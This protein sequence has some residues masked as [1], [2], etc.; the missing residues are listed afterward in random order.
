MKLHFIVTAGPTREHLDPV[1]FLSNPSTGKMGFEVAR[2]AAR[3]GHDVVLVAGPCDLPTPKGVQRVD[4]VSAREMKAAVDGALASFP[5]DGEFR[6]VL[7][8]T[9]AVADW[10]PETTAA[11][12]LKKGEMDGV[13]RLVRNPDILAETSGCL[14]IGF[15]AETGDAIE[16]AKRKCREKHA[17]LIVL[18][19]V[20]APGAGFG[21]TTNIVT[22]V[23]CDGK[24]KRLPL[25]PKSS[26]ATKIVHFAEKAA[27]KPNVM[28]LNGWAASE[29]AWDKC[30]FRRDR[31]YSYRDHLSGATQQAFDSMRGGVA[32]V[33][34]SMGVSVALQLALRNP[35]KI[36]ALVL[37]AGTPCMMQA[38]DW[39][40]MTAR[41]MEALKLGLKWTLA[42][43][44]E[45]AQAYEADSDENLD[46][47]LA[48][49]VRTDLRDELKANREKIANI[50]AI[51]MQATRDP[52]VRMENLEFLRQLF[53]NPH[54]E[55]H[56]IA[57]HA[58]PLVCAKDI[59]SAIKSFL[60]DKIF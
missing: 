15:A 42:G 6:P 17:E 39:K 58:L 50:P 25:M 26:I 12:K 27:A 11:T 37:L 13:L 10:R 34:W 38:P 9:A 56:D 47:G 21:T 29:A 16:E 53:E 33:A 32:M 19:D 59:D 18:N 40:G 8:A 28:V 46:A 7:V 52:I 30:E 45:E 3:C 1:R 2:A 31:I 41:R 5:A 60:G 20:T 22:F 51:I 44:G 43:N 14:K 55:L 23:T 48:Y 54:C 4:V 36:R 57:Q 35:S 49:L 24:E